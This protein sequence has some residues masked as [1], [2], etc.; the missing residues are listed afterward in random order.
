MALLDDLTREAATGPT[1]ENTTVDAYLDAMD[2]WLADSR[3]ALVA[4]LIEWLM[5][6]HVL[7][8]PGDFRLL[9]DYLTAVR[10][11]VQSPAD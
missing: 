3:Q 8:P 1:W 7:Y 2:A 4:D 9:T 10:R 11:R 6:R 5:V